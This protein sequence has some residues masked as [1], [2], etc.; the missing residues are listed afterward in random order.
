M[1]VTKTIPEGRTPLVRSRNSA[2]SSGPVALH[3]TLLSKYEIASYA[4]FV[5][6]DHFQLTYGRM[7]L[8]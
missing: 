4:P 3:F 2:V 6:M 8:I 1:C 5:A 7:Y